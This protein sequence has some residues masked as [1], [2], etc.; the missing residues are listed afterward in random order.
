MTKHIDTIRTV[1]DLA[2]GEQ[3]TPEPEMVYVSYPIPPRTGVELPV[4]H[5]VRRGEF[6]YAISEAGVE[7][8]VAGDGAEF[9]IRGRYTGKQYTS[10]YG[11]RS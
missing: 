9:A 8:C 2:D 6:V 3:A 5:V 11:R 10:R 4:T 7:R 1:Y